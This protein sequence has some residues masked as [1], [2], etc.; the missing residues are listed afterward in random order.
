MPPEA[1]PEKQRIHVLMAVALIAAALLADGA[2]ILELVPVVGF[3]LGTFTSF[4][5]FIIFTFWFKAL[6]VDYLDRN[7]A[8]KFLI[9]V[10][11]FAFETIPLL[12][13]IPATTLGVAA[14]VLVTRQQDGK[15]NSVFKLARLKKKHMSQARQARQA[16]AEKLAEGRWFQDTGSAAR[17]RVDEGR[18]KR[19]LKRGTREI[20]RPEGMRYDYDS[21]TSERSQP[22]VSAPL[23]KRTMEEE[24]KFA[25]G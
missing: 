15:E 12:N 5:A 23:T 7:G 11:A 22:E 14:L 9:W 8:T 10:L 20:K 19:D 16:A 13:I 2:Q 4:M 21:F 18:I 6:G 24:E 17:A 3:I 1:A 25:R